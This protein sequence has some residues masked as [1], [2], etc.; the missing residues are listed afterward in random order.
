MPIR[1]F[2]DTVVT[3]TSMPWIPLNIHR[4][5]VEASFRLSFTGNGTRIISIEYTLDNVLDADVSAVASTVMTASMSAGSTAQTFRV[6]AVG[7]RYRVVG[8]S[9]SANSTFRFLQLGI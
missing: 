3:A 1:V 6:P 8:G 5:Q 7:I 2:Q 4:D 9:A